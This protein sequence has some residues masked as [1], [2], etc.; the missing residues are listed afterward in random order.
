MDGSFEASFVG[1]KCESISG[2]L[3]GVSYPKSIP[4]QYR[5]LPNH[6]NLPLLHFSVTSDVED[7]GPNNR[8]GLGAVSGNASGI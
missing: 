4:Q 8:F 5:F 2:K 7:F 6:Q 3:L 1:A